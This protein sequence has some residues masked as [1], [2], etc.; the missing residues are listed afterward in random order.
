M[1]CNHFYINL[2]CDKR[3]FLS[4]IENCIVDSALKS[5]LSPGRVWN[6]YFINFASTKSEKWNK[7]LWHTEPKFKYP[8]NPKM[9]FNT[10]SEV[11]SNVN[12]FYCHHIFNVFLTHVKDKRSTIDTFLLSIHLLLFLIITKINARCMSVFYLLFPVHFN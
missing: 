10:Q 12:F 7:S 11:N 2:K 1:I 9:T 6:L 3:I 4:I 8:K 5:A